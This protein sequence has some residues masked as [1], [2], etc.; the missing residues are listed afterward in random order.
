ML[1]DI[2]LFCFYSFFFTTFFLLK[3]GWT[4]LH[5]AASKGFEQVVRVLL[6]HG[7]NVDLQDQVLIFILF[8]CCCCFSLVVSDEINFGSFFNFFLLSLKRPLFT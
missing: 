7:S 6:E 2:Y 8:L 1:C 3:G 4:A 5:F